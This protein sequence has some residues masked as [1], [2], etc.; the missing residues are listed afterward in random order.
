MFVTKIKEATEGG[1]GFALDCANCVPV[2]NAVLVLH[3]DLGCYTGK[4]PACVR[5]NVHM[6]LKCQRL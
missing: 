4:K 3:K 6:L 5:F 2:S 1:K